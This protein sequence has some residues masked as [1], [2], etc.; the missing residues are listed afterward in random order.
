[1]L[2]EILNWQDREVVKHFNDLTLWA[3]P[4]GRLLL[5]HIPMRKG[6]TVLDIGFGTGFPLI[7]LGERFGPESIVYGIDPWNEAVQLVEEKVQRFDIPNIRILQQDAVRIP[8]ESESVDLVTSNLGVNNFDHKVQVYQEIWR[9]LKPQ[10]SLCIT[11]NPVGTFK[12]LFDVFGVV[13]NEMKAYQKL[14]V[15][16]EYIQARG[17]KESIR[18]ELVTAGF[19]TQQIIED[20]VQMRFVDS[21]AILNH[22]LIRV[23]FRASWDSFIPE[24]KQS[25]FYAQVAQYIADQIQSK[26]S[27]SM[28]IPIL[29]LELKKG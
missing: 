26:G 28:R 22:R 2:R 23:G 25:V 9:A 19:R 24:G 27:F 10:G 16:H 5:E 21:T 8:L 18:S 11:T 12:E 17:T 4:F 1:M 20:S 6:A 29:Y 3:A 14:E 13:L 15:L 7:E